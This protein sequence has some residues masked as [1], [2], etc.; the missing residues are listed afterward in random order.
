M[1]GITKVSRINMV[2]WFTT[3]DDIV[4]A[5]RAGTNNI[6]VVN[7]TRCNRRPGRWSGLM[8]GVAGI[9]GIDVITR[10]STCNR[11]IMTT[12]AGTYYLRMIYC[13]GRNGR[14]GRWEYRMTCVTGISGINMIRCFTA[15]R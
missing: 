3:C 11:S 13:T 6:S 2:G 10:F 5:T 1:T 4:M 8:T 15:G 12:K 7:R 9:R 14:P